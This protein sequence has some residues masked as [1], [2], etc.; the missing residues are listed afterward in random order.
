MR[1]HS[2]YGIFISKKKRGVKIDNNSMFAEY[3]DVLS[4]EQLQEMLHIGR[5]T[6]YDLL[7]DSTIK[8]IKI[9]KKYIIPKA[10]VINFIL[11]NI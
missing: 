5:N 10:S 8:T 4:I 9:G 1:N 7:R 11:G 6:A 3:P 2:S